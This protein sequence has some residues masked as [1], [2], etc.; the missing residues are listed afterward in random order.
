MSDIQFTPRSDSDLEEMER[1][2]REE[3]L[4]AEGPA[5]WEVITSTSKHSQAGNPMI[6]VKFKAWDCNGKQGYVDDFFVEG[7]SSFFLKKV[8]SFCQSGGIEHVYNAGKISAHDIPPGLT[9]KFIL[10][11]KAYKG[12]LQNSIKEYTSGDKLNVD[13][14]N[15]SNLNDSLDDIEF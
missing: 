5:N 2:E 9:G 4:L 10:I 8:K 1:K 12:E 3:K 14:K 13:V 15:N 11:R 6:H 7:T